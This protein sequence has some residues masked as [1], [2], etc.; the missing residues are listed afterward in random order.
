MDRASAPD[1]AAAVS[2]AALLRGIRSGETSPLAAFDRF[3]ER[4]AAVE[5]AIG[6]F[7]A[8]DWHAARAAVPALARHPLAGLPVGVKDIYDTVSLPT[9]YG[10]P[11]YRDHHPSTDAAIVS[12]LGA[13][14]ATVPA[15]TVTTEFAFLEPAAT[16]NPHAPERSPGGSSSGSAAAVA[17]GMLPA[18]VGSQT[19]GS[20]IRPASFCGIVGFKPSYGR[21]P[22]AG[23]KHF[24]PGL[25]TVGLFT[26][27]VDS[28]GCL[29]DA[30]EGRPLTFDDPQPRHLSI[31]VPRL[32]WD[33]KAEAPAQRALEAAIMAIGRSG[34]RIVDRTL[35]GAGAAADAAQAVIMSY[36]GFRSLAEERRSH[37]GLLSPTL[38]T[39]LEKAGA[40]A[41][42]DYEVARGVAA[43]ARAASL[44]LYDGVDA[45]LTFA[46][47][48]VAPADR[49]STGSPRF[50][51][52]W[53]LLGLPC[54]SLPGI[55]DGGLP[56]GIQL[57][58]RPFGDEA[59]LAV[60]A[61]VEAALRR[62]P[63]Q[64]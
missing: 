11:I 44:R 13:A 20:T 52:L 42:A 34:M 9:E 7:A 23:I 32:P 24:A 60:A 21:L 56:I 48:D 61:H 26:A 1:L 45:L 12:L 4:A 19:A 63:D 5:P 17:A 18:A 40:I 55:V 36:E 53:T 41:P 57:V 46:A 16:R 8:A 59:L 33:G 28:M 58:G 51:R 27:D 54:L 6:A 35:P 25:D 38:A 29:F 2:L 30:L 3:A 64:P 15:K 50:N 62:S 39:Y 10:S 47:A 22:V 31:A 43:A 49:S 14:G 37:S